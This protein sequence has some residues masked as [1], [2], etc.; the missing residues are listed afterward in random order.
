VVAHRIEELDVKSVRI[1]ARERGGHG[2]GGS[3]MTCTG[4]RKQKKEALRGGH[5][6]AL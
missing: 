1:S 5:A 4:V 3:A 6:R 2:L